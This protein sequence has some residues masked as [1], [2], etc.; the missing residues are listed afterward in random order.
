MKIRHMGNRA[1]LYATL[2][3]ML[4]FTLTMTLLYNDNYIRLLQRYCTLQYN[5]TNDAI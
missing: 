2:T 5:V 3:L 1:L 4:L